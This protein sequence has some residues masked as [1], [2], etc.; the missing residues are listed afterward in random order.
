MQCISLNRH[1]KSYVHVLLFLYLLFIV[2]HP[3]RHAARY[4]FH[5]GV[6]DVFNELLFENSTEKALNLNYC[7][8]KDLILNNKQ[9][10]I[11]ELHK[12]QQFS[13]PLLG[14]V[15]YDL[16]LDN[17]FFNNHCFCF[18]LIYCFLSN[19]QGVVYFLLNIKFNRTL[20]D[21]SPIFL[22]FFVGTYIKILFCQ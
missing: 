6:E 21:V 3:G 8:Y 12:I 13:T 9:I 15:K 1:F 20:A 11:N 17:T 5:I 19:K 22:G 16:I 4:Y 2:Y 7:N 14:T 18:V 10:S